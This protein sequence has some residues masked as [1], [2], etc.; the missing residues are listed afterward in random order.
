MLAFAQRIAAGQAV[1]ADVGIK[2]VVADVGSGEYRAVGADKL[3][4]VITGNQIGEGVVAVGIGGFGGQQRAGGVI[5]AGVEIDGDAGSAGLAGILHAVGI[6]VVP[7]AV[8]DRTGLRRQF[9]HAGVY[10]GVVLAGGEGV[11][12][13]EAIGARVGVEGVAADVGCGQYGAVGSNELDDVVAGHQAGEAVVAVGIGGGA[14]HE[15]AGGV[16]DAGVELDADPCAAGLAG[17]LHAVGVGVVPYAVTEAGGGR[18]AFDHAGVDGGVVLAGGEGVAAGKA[19]CVGVRVEGVAGDVGGGKHCAVGADE[20]DDVVAG[21]DVG[22]TVIAVGVGGFDGNQFARCTIDAG[23]ELNV[24]AFLAEF[25]GILH[26]IGVG[27]DP[28]AVAQRCGFDQAGVDGG[29]VLAGGEG[30]AAGQAVDVGVGVEGV[31]ADVGGAQ[32]G[33]VGGDELDD[34]VAGHEAGKVVVAVGVGGGAGHECAG[35]VI[36]AGVELDADPCAAGLAGILHAVG[37]GVV[38]HPVAQ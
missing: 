37:V 2:G 28:D 1:C 4:N 29:V 31:V 36:D 33:A 10:G 14:G 11:A 15:C 22:E 26:A 3:K 23:K 12:T 34:V 38:P 21:D 30:V 27:V 5:D 7:Y 8:T 20:L 16:I 13:G 6:G 25:A 24:D 9:D 17:I 35:G 19:V 18:G 32:Y